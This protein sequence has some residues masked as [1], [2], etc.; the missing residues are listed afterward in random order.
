MARVAALHG[1]FKIYGECD[2]DHV[3]GDG[4][5]HIDAIGLTCEDGFEYSIC[6]EC[7]TNGREQTEECATYHDHVKFDTAH[8]KTMRA[9]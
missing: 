1:P 8:C 3:D 4:S 9:M 7:C 6:S 5:V 2:H